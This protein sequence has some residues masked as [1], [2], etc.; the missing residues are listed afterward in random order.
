MPITRNLVAA[1]TA[2]TLLVGIPAAH[3]AQA[4]PPPTDPAAP[5]AQAQK[6]KQAPFT[7]AITAGRAAV[8]EAL[9]QP[10]TTSASVAFVHDGK[11]VWSQTF[12]RGTTAGKK[13]TPTQKYGIG[14]VSKTVTAVAIMQ[15]VDQGK[16][17]LDAP[18]VQY[19]PDF[20]MKSPQYRQ[21]TVRM[22]LNHSA[23][24]PGTDYSDGISSEPIA[25]YVERVLAGLRNSHLKT[26][27]GA[28]NV[29]CNDCFTLA[30][31]VVKRVS[32]MSLPDYVADNIFTP[33]RM[34]HSAYPSSIPAPG[35]YAPDIYGGKKQ[36]F[37]VTNI[38]A[39]GGLLSTSDDMAQFAK[40]FTGDGVV[41]GKRILSSSAIQ[42]M[43]VDQTAT[44]LR[45]AA[46]GS[47]RFGLG[48]DTMADPALKSAGV[49]GWTKGGDIGQYHAGFVVAPDQRMAV[50]VE[51][52]GT[53]FSSSSA[54]TIAHTVLLKA[55]VETG[56]IKGMPK[57]VAGP[58]GKNKVT[59]KQ[60]KRK[61]RKITGVYLAQGTS[62]KVAKANKSSITLSVTSNGDWERVPGRL[63][64]RNDGTFWGTTAPSSL[65]IMRAW[66]RT[67]LVLRKPGG[68]GTYNSASTMG[69]RTR[70]GG[71]LS[72][73]WQ[74]RVGHTWLLANENPASLSWTNSGSPTIDIN[75]I[76][77]VSGYLMASGALV[78]SVPFDARASDTVGSMFLEVP[79]LSG[80][81][82]YDFEFTRNG[83]DEFLSFSSSVL[84]PAATVTP[85]A[86]GSTAVTIGA[87]GLVEWRKTPAA[88]VTLSG[89][90]DWKLFDKELSII[91]SGGS[92]TTAVEAPAGS[93]LA[94]FGP[95][96]RTATV[97]AK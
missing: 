97:V 46:P 8:R 3:N 30:G 79:L 57:P 58:P 49:R 44:T 31:E 14:S 27:P 88:I 13:P 59:Q 50:V 9:K 72:P 83:A 86:S 54:E 73:A 78:E 90:S 33:L 71:G 20:T 62:F 4:A 68:T 21:I 92:A 37:E 1:L 55:M 67:Y 70:S 22:L 61:I 69:Q 51:G 23:G 28:M 45:V 60:A 53:G 15:L 24:L 42:Q 85:L 35:T 48:W 81:D 12:G 80:R 65:R 36:P 89:Q 47:F 84:R 64:L 39:S 19:L 16:V 93:Y 91:D 87:E 5:V 32:G 96:G 18:V 40:V 56:D 95:P 52:A 34:R 63:V 25:G 2:G 43:S 7:A 26:T 41:N 11:T 38:W 94:I 17:S 75:A 6:P 10:H 77:G 29:Y 82:L 66:D 74:A 76:P